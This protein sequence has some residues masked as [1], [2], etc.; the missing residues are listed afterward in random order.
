VNQTIA[1][2]KDRVDTLEYKALNEDEDGMILDENDA[3]DGSSGGRV[4]SSGEGT[5]GHSK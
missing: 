3:P 1:K 5:G 4:T 2:L